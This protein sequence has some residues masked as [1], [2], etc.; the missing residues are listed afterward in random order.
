MR[1]GPPGPLP[2][3]VLLGG[4]AAA[5]TSSIMIR[6]AQGLGLPSISIAA[7]RMALASLI[8][9]PVV[10]LR[11]RAWWWI[12]AP[13]RGPRPATWW[14]RATPGSCAMI[15]SSSSAQ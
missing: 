15:R 8:L 2:Y 3:L 13:R 14:P 11:G 4:I 9:L 10:L 6:L 12:S 5:S 7:G 1:P